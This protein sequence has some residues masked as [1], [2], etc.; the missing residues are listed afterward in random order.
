DWE[1][2]LARTHFAIEGTQMFTGLLFVPKRPPFDLY[3]R[4]QRRGV[5][6]YVKRV[7]I[8]DDC[9]E[10]V[11]EYLRFLRGVIDS[12]DL[13]LNV[14]REILQQERMVRT[15]RGQVV[16]KTL[17]LLEELMTSKPDVYK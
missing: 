14:S 9:E 13:P 8:M 6:L 1:K 5:R 15:I 3:D 16:K 11:P 2:P 12:D 7:F 4:N 10:L 17:D